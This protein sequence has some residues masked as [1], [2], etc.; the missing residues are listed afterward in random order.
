MAKKCSGYDKIMCLTKLGFTVNG[1]GEILE[2]FCPHCGELII[3]G[4]G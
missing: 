1:K 3:T 4:E 2:K